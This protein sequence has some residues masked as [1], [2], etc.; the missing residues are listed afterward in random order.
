MTRRVGSTRKVDFDQDCDFYQELTSLTSKGILVHI[1]VSMWA[2]HPDGCGP[3]VFYP[4]KMIGLIVG[5]HSNPMVE[6]RHSD[7][8][9]VGKEYSIPR[10]IGLVVYWH[11]NMMVE[12]QGYSNPMVDCTHRVFKVS[13]FKWVDECG[14]KSI[15]QE[16]ELMGLMKI[17][18]E[19]MGLMK[20]VAG[21]LMFNAIMLVIVV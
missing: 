8:M 2:F 6:C 16:D 18:A 10:M 4:S 20:I 1:F 7:P 12:G 15:Q 21:L 17:F 13:F 14:N 5:G 11:S 19:L 9:V 3:G